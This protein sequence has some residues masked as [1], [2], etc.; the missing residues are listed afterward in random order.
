[1]D[2]TGLMTNSA[3]NPNTSVIPSQ[4]TPTYRELCVPWNAIFAS[5][6]QPGECSYPSTLPKRGQKSEGPKQVTSTIYLSGVKTKVRRVGLQVHVA[7][8]P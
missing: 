4:Q 1:M 6:I 2:L 8:S 5:L 3:P 7:C